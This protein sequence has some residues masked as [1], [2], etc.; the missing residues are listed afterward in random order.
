MCHVLVIEDEYLIS[1][2]ITSL[3]TE[4]G[5]TSVTQVDTEEDAVSAAR[6]RRPDMIM[7]DV[8]LACG[9]GPLAVQ[10]I[11]AEHGPIPVIF[12]T[13]SPEACSPC[14][15]PAVI[16]GKPILERAVIQAFRQLSGQDNCHVPIIS[17]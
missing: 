13:G 17:A 5:A 10:T 1:D 6:V 9:S 3:A 7:S 8:K 2:H 16:L 11:L 12:I 14:N 4:A 15:L